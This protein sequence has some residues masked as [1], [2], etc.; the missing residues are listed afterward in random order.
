MGQKTPTQTP[1][2]KDSST[3]TSS[4]QTTPPK[5]SIIVGGSVASSNTPSGLD[6]NANDNVGPVED[7]GERHKIGDHSITSG[8]IITTLLIDDTIT[9]QSAPDFVQKYG[10]SMR[11][12][13]EIQDLN[14]AISLISYLNQSAPGGGLR[15]AVQI[16][17]RT[18]PYHL[19]RIPNDNRHTQ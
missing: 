17:G 3:N 9:K 16:N 7:T 19:G 14:Q 10:S 5:E 2:L 18:M 8:S 11:G 13:G 6:A 4:H 12:S 1:E 15:P